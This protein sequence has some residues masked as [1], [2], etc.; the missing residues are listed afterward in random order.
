MPY[1]L[2][3]TTLA[4]R[5]ITALRGPRRKA[6]DVFVTELAAVGC[7]ALTYRLTGDD[8]LRR[9][10]VRHL[11]GQDHALVDF[12]GDTAWILLVG[13]LDAADRRADVYTSLYQLAGVMPPVEFAG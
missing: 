7:A 1:D 3:A 13:P 8:P 4:E 10:Y 12:D 5:Q 11:R 2:R 6:F 9:L